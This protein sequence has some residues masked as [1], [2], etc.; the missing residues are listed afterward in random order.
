MRPADFPAPSSFTGCTVCCH[1]D[2]PRHIY[3]LFQ[4]LGIQYHWVLTRG[5]LGRE[6]VKAEDLAIDNAKEE[7]W[8]VV[9]EHEHDLLEDTLYH[10]LVSLWSKFSVTYAVF[11]QHGPAQLL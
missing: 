2:V 8:M 4:A 9:Y 5:T 10:C 1:E 7:S 6:F 11:D 3:G